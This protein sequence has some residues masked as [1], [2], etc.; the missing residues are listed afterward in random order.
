[1]ITCDGY[2]LTMTPWRCIGNQLSDFCLPGFPCHEC[3]AGV[4]LG[5]KDGGRDARPA[6]RLEARATNRK[7]KT[8]N[9]KQLL[10]SMSRAVARDLGLI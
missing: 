1:M 4:G 10:K 8:E 3:Q 6:H 5:L 9:R 7:L 2:Q